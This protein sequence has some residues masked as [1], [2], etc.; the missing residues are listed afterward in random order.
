[1]KKM[2]SVSGAV[3][4][5]SAWLSGCMM[6]MCGMGHGD[7]GASPAG[8]VQEKAA[9]T[10]PAPEPAKVAEVWVCPMG[11]YTGS[12][13]GKCPKCGMDLVPAAK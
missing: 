10:A 11:E 13:P 5:A 6:P 7:H 4:F 1:M 2:L 12:A 8:A 9:A 3:L